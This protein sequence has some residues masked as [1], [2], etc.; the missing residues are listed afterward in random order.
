MLIKL[1][2]SIDGKV[3]HLLVN[4]DDISCVTVVGSAT[5]IQFISRPRDILSLGVPPEK[6]MDE[7]VTAKNQLFYEACLSRGVSFMEGKS[8]SHNFSHEASV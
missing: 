7:I 6:I 2:D 8:F 3:R 1:T 4:P 5:C